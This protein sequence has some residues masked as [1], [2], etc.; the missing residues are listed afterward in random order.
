MKGFTTTELIVVIAL[1]LLFAALA[2][3]AFRVAQKNSELEDASQLLQSVLRLAQSRTLASEG[4][5]QYGVFFDTT[6]SPDQYVLFKGSSYAT[7]DISADEAH[8]LP[9][10]VE[11]SA[12]TMPGSE[13]V[14]VRLTGTVLGSGSVTLRLLSDPTKQETVYVSSSGAIQKTS[15]F[16]PSDAARVKDSRHVH[17][18]YTGRTINT[19]T[20][21]LRLI[22]GSTTY[23]IVIADNLLAGQISWQ[24]NIL[25]DGETQ[26][27]QVQ[28]HRLN[29]LVLGTQFSIVRDKSK[30]T[31]ALTIEISG[32]STGDLIRYDAA[33]A[34]TK[35]SSVYVSIPLWQ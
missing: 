12:V 31:K 9:Q 15:S 18:D 8:V 1:A 21:R 24:G 26:T 33:G 22:F 34:T 32:D 25:V 13:V 5:S 35:G 7:R 11:I 23:E 19:A 17:Q 20:E 27:L 30:N 4:A 2:I 29:D 3:P 16:M 6:T 28:T 14:F 10:G